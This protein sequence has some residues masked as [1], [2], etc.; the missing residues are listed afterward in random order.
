MQSETFDRTTKL[1]ALDMLSDDYE[2][3]D[4]TVEQLLARW[5]AGNSIWSI[6]MGS[7]GPSYEQAIQVM[8]VE[9][10]RALSKSTGHQIDDMKAEITRVNRIC[11]EVL[12]GID[13]E[14]GGAT[15]AM[16]GAARTLAWNWCYNGGPKSTVEMFPE[17][18]HIQVSKSWPQLSLADET[19]RVL[20]EGG[21]S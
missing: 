15:G 5:D 12:K 17:D 3:Y 2:A 19:Y 20:Q 14:I 13:N 9:F 11:D 8:A 16:F 6:S 18:R 21:K 7:L 10:A 4:D 1:T